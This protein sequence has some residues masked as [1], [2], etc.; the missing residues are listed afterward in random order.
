M[1]YKRRGGLTPIDSMPGSDHMMSAAEKGHES[2]LFLFTIG[3]GMLHIP[4][5]TRLKLQRNSNPQ[6]PKYKVT[7]SLLHM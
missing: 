4:G 1:D 6:Y 2:Q 7:L 5:R 3:K